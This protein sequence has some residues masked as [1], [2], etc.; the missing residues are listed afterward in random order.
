MAQPAG[1]ISEIWRFPVKSMAGENL[2]QALLTQAGLYGDRAMAVFDVET[3]KV[4]SAKNVRD[5]PA[6]MA[7]HAAYEH[8]PAPNE[9]L[10]NIQI[11]LS[12]GQTLDSLAADA[13]KRLSDFF[14]REVRLISDAPESFVVDQYHPDLPGLNPAGNRD[15]VVPQPLGASLFQALGQEAP[16]APNA[17]QDLFPLSV[18]TTATVQALSATAP[19][20]DFATA[21]FRMNVIINTDENPA[22]VG[23]IENGWAGQVGQVGDA[24][25]HFAMPDPR[26]VMVTRATADI[27]EDTEVLR[28]IAQTNR[29]ELPGIGAYPCAGVYAVI[30]QAGQIRLGDPLDLRS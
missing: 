10:P 29:L 15:I 6:L 7:C 1:H 28:A 12:N 22:A 26:C 27:P 9:T 13:D 30:A 5:F 3:G 19:T 24:M 20:A 21:R 14:G 17:L 2:P 23:P 25:V 18:M 4:A 8:P 11:T 16:L